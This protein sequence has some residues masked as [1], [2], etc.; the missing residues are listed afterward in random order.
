M[1]LELRR[2]RICPGWTRRIDG[3]DMRS[4][5]QSQAEAYLAGRLSCEDL[6]LW[7]VGNLQD[8]LD[9]GDTVGV[10][11]ANATDADL[12]ELNDGLLSEAEFRERLGEHL[13][14]VGSDSPRSV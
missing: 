9:S 2:R 7:L 3:G 14:L 5:L 8:I 6:E 13:Q 10:T 4:S 12:I 1:A 11:A